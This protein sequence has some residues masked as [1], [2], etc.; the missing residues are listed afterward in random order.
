MPK[1]IFK[2]GTSTTE[3]E[4]LNGETLLEAANRNGVKIFGGCGGAGVCGTCH[5]VI[6]P[7][8]TSKLK[9]ASDSEAD[10]LDVLPNAAPLSR[11]ACQVVISDEL[12]GV[13]V[14]V[15]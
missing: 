12:D 5:V 1:I 3:V 10:V 15:P 13:T 6:D 9:P 2:H 14:A 8:Y 11:L 4:A 7:A